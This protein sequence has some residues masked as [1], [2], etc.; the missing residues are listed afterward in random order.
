MISSISGN[1]GITRLSGSGLM[2]LVGY[3]PPFL[4]WMGEASHL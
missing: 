2:S 1:P 3:L 4:G